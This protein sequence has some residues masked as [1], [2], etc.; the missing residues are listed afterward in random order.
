[1][2][3]DV[4]LLT[5]FPKVIYYS[6]KFCTDKLDYLTDAIQNL[7]VSTKKDTALSVNS[8]HTT[9]NQLHLLVEFKEF[10]ENILTSCKEY[11][12]SLGYSQSQCDSLQIA[13]MWFNQSDQGD[14]LFPHIHK[15]SM[16]SGGAYIKTPLDNTIVFQELSDMMHEPDEPNTLS[17]SSQWINCIPGLLLIF[18]RDI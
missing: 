14:F 9:Y 3:D 12:S 2:N 4:Q 18:K 1:M 13:N 15:G 5:I 6:P 8:S 10:A 17:Y 16:F 11:S 7:P